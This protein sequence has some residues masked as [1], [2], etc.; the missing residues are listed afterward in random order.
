MAKKSTNLASD[1]TRLTPQPPRPAPARSATLRREVLGVLMASKLAGGSLLIAGAAMANPQNGTVVAGNASIV[2]AT[3]E[4]LNVVQTSDRA[5]INWQNFSI[6]PGEVT[7]FQQPNAASVTLN[8]VTG[9]Q[10]STLAGSLTANGTVMLI[11]PNGVVISK[12]GTVDVSGLVAT[13]ANIKDEDFMANRLKFDQAAPNPNAAVRNEGRISIKNQGLAALVAPSVQNS[14]VIEAKLGKVSLGGAQT[15]SLDFQGDGLLSFS[16][17]SA[18][19]VAPQDEQGVPVKALV[20][21]SGQILAEGG[22]V[23]LTASAVKSVIDQ[24]INTSGVIEARSVAA[25]EGR[26][27]LSGGDAGQ[28][29][30]SG[31]LDVSSNESGGGTIGIN[32]E[33]V[34]ITS[35]AR[36]TASGATGGGNI[37]IGHI[38]GSELASTVQIARGAQVNADAIVNGNGGEIMVLSTDST[39]FAGNVSAR[40]GVEGGN[41]GNVEISSHDQISLSGQVDL[42]ASRGATGNLLIDPATLNIIDGAA[43]S[44]DQDGAAGDG[45]IDSADIN[46]ANN[47]ISRGTLE[48]LSGTANVTLEAVGLITIE[49]MAGNLI[50]LQTD[51]NHSFTLRSTTS[52]GIQFVNANT[53]IRTQGGDIFLLALKT[54]MLLNTGILNSNGGDIWVTAGGTVQLSNTLNAGAGNVNI[55]SLS[56]SIQNTGSTNAIGGRVNV[57]AAFGNV[58]TS[59][60][61]IN[62]STANL[63]LATGGDLLVNNDTALSQLSITSVHAASTPFQYE[64]TAPQLTFDVTDDNTNYSL[65]SLVNTGGNLALTFQGDRNLIVG[66]VNAVAGDVT[67]IST[68]GAIIDDGNP[69]TSIT[70]DDLT[71]TTTGAIG[72]NTV[73]LTSAVNSLTAT[74]GGTGGAFM[75]NTGALNLLSLTAGGASNIVSTGDLT[76]GLVAAAGTQLTLTSSG[77]SVFS[78]GGPNGTIAAQTLNLNGSGGAVGTVGTNIRTSATAVNATAVNGIYVGTTGAT[79]LGTVA[80]TNGPVAITSAGN[81]TV[82]T[83]NAGASG[84][85]ALTTTSGSISASVSGQN[86]TANTFTYSATG[87]VTLGTAANTISG[88]AGSNVNLTQTGATTLSSLTNTGSL[89]VNSTAG[90]VTLGSLQ[91]SGAATIV[92]ANGNVIDDANG[93]TALTANA[94]VIS[95]ALGSLGT[96]AQ[97]LQTRTASLNLSSGGDIYVDNNQALTSLTVANTHPTPGVHVLDINS[98]YLQWDVVDNGT[99]FLLNDIT[100]LTLN[101][102]SFTG[103]QTAIVN[104]VRASSAAV[105]VRATLGDVLN[106]GDI[107]TRITGSNITLT[108]DHGN[109]GA[110]GAGNALDIN[111]AQLTATTA[112]NLY[113]TDINDLSTLTV[114]STHENPAADYQFILNAAGLRFDIVDSA[115]GYALNNVRDV[116]SL[117]FTFQ[118]DRTITAGTLDMT[119]NG[120]VTLTSTG[121]SVLDDG[122]KTTQILADTV[123]LRAQGVGASVG[124]TT[125]NGFMDVISRNL[126]GQSTGSYTV[127]LPHPT[128]TTNTNG[129]VTLSSISATGPIKVTVDNG[130]L[131]VTNATSASTIQLTATNGSILSSSTLSSTGLT[132][133]ASGAI[134]A[135]NSILNAQTNGTLTATAAGGGL[136]LSNN[137]AISLLTATAAGP[138]SLTGNNN[139]TAGAIGAGANPVTITASSSLLDDGNAATRIVGSNVTL[140][141]NNGSMGSATAGIAVTAPLLS[142]TSGGDVY[143]DDSVGVTSLSILGSSASANRTNIYSMTAPGLTLTASDN[144]SV[145]TLA[146]VDNATA[147]TFA[148]Q[149]QRTLALGDIDTNSGSATLTSVLSSSNLIDDGNATTTIAAPTLTLSAGNSIGASGAGNALAIDATT[150]SLTA[151]RDFYVADSSALTSLTM[152][153]NATTSVTNNFGITAAGQTFTL[154]DTGSV[155]YLQTLSGAGLN[156]FTFTSRKDL[157]LGTIAATNSVRLNTTGG[158][159]NTIVMDGVGGSK[160]TSGSVTLDT[161]GSSVG[162]V[163]TSTTSIAVSTPSLTVKTT[164]NAYVASDTNL[165]SLTLQQ[166]HSST[167]VHYATAIAAPNISAFNFTDGSTAALDDVTATNMN[168]S[169]DTDRALQVGTVNVGSGSASLFARSSTS[170]GAAIT[171]DGNQGTGITAGPVQLYSSLGYVGASGNG[172]ID[173]T[174]SSLTVRS[175]GDIYVTDNAALSTLS[176]DASH[177]QS[178]NRTY[179]IAATGLTFNVVDQNFLVQGGLGTVIHDVDNG[180]ADLNFSLISDRGLQ[181]VTLDAGTGGN[182]L[183]QSGSIS[184]DANGATKITGNRLTLVGSSAGSSSFS[185]LTELDTDIVSLATTLTSQLYLVEDSDLIL[186]AGSVTSLANITS[187]NGSIFGDGVGTFTSANLTLRADTGSLGSSGTRMTLNVRT[188]SLQTGYDFFVNNASDLVS[189]SVNDLHDIART[190]TLSIVAPN[191]TF[192]ITDAGGN[193]F[194]MTHVTDATGLDFTFTGDKDIQVFTVDARGGNSVSISTSSSD[195]I[196]DDGNG[197]TEITGESVAFFSGG[198][199]GL[200][201]PME[202]NT[203]NLRITAVDDFNVL[204]N[205]DLSALNIT[206]STLTP[207]SYTLIAPN[208]AFDLSGDGTTILVTNVTDSTGLR[209]TLQTPNP[210]S[211]QVI[212]TQTYGYVNLFSSVAMTGSGSVNS[213]ITAGSA[214]LQAYTGG[215]IGSLANPMELSVPLL[216]VLNSGDFYIDSDTHIDSLTVNNQH[217]N[218]GTY[219]IVSPSLTF[220]VT[221]GA[222]GVELTDIEDTTGLNLT[223]TSDHDFTIGDINLGTAGNVSLTSG[224][225][226]GVDFSGDGDTNTLITAVGVNFNTLSGFIGASGAG[227]AIDVSAQNFSAFAGGGGVFTDFTGP[228]LI[229]SLYAT[230]GSSIEDDGDIRINGV[231]TNGQSLSV[232]SGGSILSGNISNASTLTLTAAGSIGN[233]SAISTNANGAGTT[234]LTATAGGSVALNETYSLNASSVTANG[235]VT[236][237]SNLGNLSVGTVN[238][239]A[240]S[241]VV[242]TSS[243]G[244]ITANNGANLITGSAVT[245]NAAYSQAGNSIGTVG[246]PVRVATP[247][248]TLNA[249]GNL[250]V[251]GTTDLDALTITRAA[252]SSGSPGG[253]L[254]VTATNLTLSG[255]DNGSTTTLTTLTDSTGLNFSLTAYDQIAVNNINVGVNSDVT[256]NSFRSVATGAITA[257]GA[258]PLVTA[259]NLTLATS[260]DNLGFIGTSGTPFSTAVASLN[261]SAQTGGIFVTQSGALILNSVTSGGEVNVNTTSGNLTVGTVSYGSGQALTLGA[262]AS[263]LDDGVNSTVLVGSGAGPINLSAVTALGTLASPFAITDNSTNTINASVT[264]TGS[265]YLNVTSAANPLI[266]ITA[267]NGSINLRTSGT[268]TLSSLTSTTDAVGNDVNVTALTGNIV[269][270]SIT[271]GSQFGALDLRSNAGAI[272]GLTGSNSLNAF[273]ATLN[274]A[275]GIGTSGTPLNL[276]VQSISADTLAGGVYLRQTGAA[277]LGFVRSRNGLVNVTGTG[278]MVAA[279]VIG[280]S[281]VTLTT[282]GVGST[283][284]AGNINSGSGTLTL[285][286]A[287]GQIRDDGGPTTIVTGGAANLTAANGIGTSSAPLQTALTSLTANTTATGGLY[288]EQTGNLALSTLNAATG[289]IRVNGSGGL[290][291]SGTI[292]S[293]GERITLT[294]NGGDVALSGAISTVGGN[295][296]NALVNISGNAITVGNVTSTGAQQYNADTTVNGDLDASSIVIDGDLALGGSGDREFLLSINGGVIT[297]GAVDGNGLGLTLDAPGGTIT[298]DDATDLASLTAAAGTIDIHDVAT[299][300]DQSYT[301]NVTFNSDYTTGGG[302]FTV[303]GPLTIGSNTTVTT[304][305]GAV[306]F[307]STVDGAHDLTVDADSG[308]VTFTGTIGDTTRLGNL[309]VNTSGLTTF[310]STIKAASVTTNVPGTLSLLGDVNTTGAQS[311]GEI[312]TLTGDR[313]FTGTTVTF[314]GAVNGTTAGQESLTVVGNAVL[315]GG[316]GGTTALEFLSLSGGA[317]LAGNIATTGSQSYGGAINLNGDTTFTVGSGIAFDSTIDGAHALTV[318]AGSSNVTFNEAVGG[319]TAVTDMV[320]NSSGVSTFNTGVHAATLTTDAGGTT[321]LNANA[322]DTT[323]AQSFG[324]DITL[325]A[326]AMLTGTSITL[327]GA[328]NDATAGEH[329]LVIAGNAIFDQAVGDTAA[330]KSVSVSGTSAIDGGSVTTSTTQTYGGAVALGADTTLTGSTITTNGAIDAATAGEQSLNI[331]GNSTFNG[332]VGGT[333]ALEMLTVSGTSALNGAINT[334]GVQ[335]YTGA[336]TLAGDTTLNSGGNGVTFASTLDGAQALTINTG[337]GDTL[338]GGAIGGTTRLGALT[339][340]TAGATT[341]NGAV[342]SAS[343]VTDAPGTLA[344]NGGLVDTTGSQTYGEVAL[345]SAD[346]TLTGTAINF[347]ETL[348]DTVAGQHS[349]TINGGAVFSGAVGNLA[350]LKSLSVTGPAAIDGGSIATTVSQT[351]GGDVTTSGDTTLTLGNGASEFIGSLTAATGSI[352]LDNG[353]TLAFITNLPIHAATGFIVSGTGAVALASDITV[354]EGPISFGGPL[355]LSGAMREMETNGDITFAGIAGPNTILELTAGTG[356]VRG[357]VAGG[358]P[359]NQVVLLDMVINTA[360]SANLFGS[361]NGIGGGGTAKYVKGPLVGP[362]YFFND[363]PFGPLEF[364]DR[365]AV[366][367]A[368]QDVTAG[369]N[370]STWVDTE[371]TGDFPEGGQIQSLRA[372]LQPNLLAVQPVV[373]G[374]SGENCEVRVIN[375]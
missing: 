132:L 102:L 81:M 289:E 240:S 233:T 58:G 105:T 280:T 278:D 143:V 82:N 294:A 106:D 28:V 119:R 227:N 115:S 224:G 71:L 215:G 64:V 232:T 117:G 268:M 172:D 193:Q 359:A 207:Q 349:V 325:G 292:T 244:N 173:V 177:S 351:Y 346:T 370:Q 118:G 76:A 100:D 146:Q 220:V 204:S 323:G 219:S 297:A 209:F 269:F 348:N 344:L 133:S 190:N 317:N 17:G 175:T 153:S 319:T 98:P 336:V 254:S 49:A 310:G 365:L 372:P 66:N 134:G 197:A 164:G 94:V 235:P 68:A 374:C 298:L 309:L 27:V 350:A 264:G 96:S 185:T 60:A 24:V 256:L 271:A 183:L 330:L 144:G 3:P 70:G 291:G 287:N 299:T 162:S 239:G 270:G 67:L 167:S 29:R 62:T 212:D 75:S 35:S 12:T 42:N 126:Q 356:A 108:A 284:S 79:A 154:S 306:T 222:G 43:S 251:T 279:N 112:A 110:T 248:L 78:A 8:R 148:F 255:T 230:A 182:I 33:H 324:D 103:D 191:L 149:T 290:T 361:L 99:Q 253:A 315:N 2:A 210:L 140:T 353:G 201:D 266:N 176:I 19:A 147:L 69:A 223:W 91:A 122:N 335:T 161:S 363:V 95:S 111:T 211:V 171:D 157:R 337:A 331:V 362:P 127:A 131:R 261:A 282:S 16:A 196:F 195:D 46:T 174:T 265:A 295:I 168:F 352:T 124:S 334:A 260:G 277:V 347:L 18:V 288:I 73:S 48:A 259:R 343:V 213:R 267:N 194:D 107:D 163:G 50:D 369:N 202:V 205:M 231:N 169:Y 23:H 159:S 216:T 77:G 189:L 326:D 316:A 300:A 368:D 180:G 375:K 313:T 354:T 199:V 272:N 74:A 166:T 275:T 318:N 312:L 57:S 208:L 21:N 203:T 141:A 339:V 241:P 59:A 273:D 226:G 25:N 158:S 121:G 170:G 53:E 139:I 238:A 328:V 307:T 200:V 228:V 104:K 80:S 45:I 246:T 109:L 10:A 160:V 364:V 1:R 237:S 145:V 93:A 225:A 7:D 87:A 342:H 302:A 130:D 47:T 341:F 332:S 63:V 333:R 34:A 184:D 192:D 138:I 90:N 229:N 327:H 245:L 285:T 340:N 329:A 151:L 345:V 84:A 44:G 214:S 217:G 4:R 37:D 320:V 301:G 116:T 120:S 293:G 125:G 88:T 31:T 38:D 296:S 247:T 85:V 314:N 36:I 281:G 360:A 61:P 52:G 129:A 198:A 137:G 338:F 358:S 321:V 150:L 263:L 13:T 234:T 92:A 186:G 128:N 366:H 156:D 357:G 243:Q 178:G 26:I 97:H 242:L 187:L 15:F 14:G 188:L 257:T 322:V 56:G 136:Y 283:L 30:V 9:S 303:T 252:S 367:T 142:L 135:A 51:A 113:I 250:Y 54:G 5:I 181:V 221:D 262:A 179:A 371:N 258:N 236:L 32:G 41:G 65:S 11:N 308:A 206:V 39:R 304:D 152:R 165:S 40:G 114:R 22:T 155:H 276:V 286:A 355:T 83:V 20:N 55:T 305:G 249:R 218:L 72:S 89:T 123:N 274:A 311:Y 86:V 101:V 6:D 373:E